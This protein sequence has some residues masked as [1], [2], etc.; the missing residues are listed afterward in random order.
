MASLRSSF[1]EKKASKVAYNAD[2]KRQKQANI[3]I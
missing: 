2:E 3:S 1:T